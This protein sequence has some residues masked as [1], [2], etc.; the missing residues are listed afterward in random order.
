VKPRVACGM[1]F[2]S[3]ECEPVMK[4]KPEST[5]MIHGQDHFGHMR[6]DS[7]PGSDWEKNLKNW[8]QAYDDQ[9]EN[10]Y[11]LSEMNSRRS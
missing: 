8:K 1:I 7:R 3:T 10:Y 11:A 2:A 9:H 4:N 5:V 6:H